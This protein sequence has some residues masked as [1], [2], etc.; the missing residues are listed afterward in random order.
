[1]TP[2]PPT[3]VFEEGPQ[4]SVP[5]P[6][7]DPSPG[8]GPDSSTNPTQFSAWIQ[9]LSEFANR[10]SDG[11]TG[12]IQELAKAVV[13]LLLLIA[14]LRL[15]RHALHTLASMAWIATAVGVA[16]VSM[17]IALRS[18]VDTSPLCNLAHANSL[19]AALVR[20]LPQGT[21]PQV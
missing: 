2:N 5:G 4:S 7:L 13:V 11:T 16:G 21:C 20:L 10:S 6:S 15:T 17:W 8:P 12:L 3:P 9:I 18:G 19:V 1:M 14:C